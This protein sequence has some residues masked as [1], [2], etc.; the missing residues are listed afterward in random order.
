MKDVKAEDTDTSG[1]IVQTEVNVHIFFTDI[2][3]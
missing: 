1:R 3:I 2:E